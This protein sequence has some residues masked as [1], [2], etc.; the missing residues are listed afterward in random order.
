MVMFSHKEKRD[1]ETGPVVYNCTLVDFVVLKHKH[2]LGYITNSSQSETE[3][4]S[5][6]GRASRCVACVLQLSVK[7]FVKSLKRDIVQV[8]FFC[9][10]ISLVCLFIFLHSAKQHFP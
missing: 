8:L 3:V 2:N 5:A 4:T 10:R 6:T 1:L 9:R 7:Q